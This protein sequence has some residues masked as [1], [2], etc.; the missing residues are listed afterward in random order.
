M[1][2]VPSEFVVLELDFV[3]V[4]QLFGDVADSF[5]QSISIKRIFSEVISSVYL[6]RNGRRSQFPAYFQVVEGIAV[7]FTIFGHFILIAIPLF[8]A[9]SFSFGFSFLFRLLLQQMA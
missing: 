1:V 7:E 4:W 6:L 8:M 9:F 3:R 2:L 5:V